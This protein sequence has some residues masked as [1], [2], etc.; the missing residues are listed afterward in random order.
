MYPLSAPRLEFHVAR[1]ETVNASWRNHGS[2]DLF[3]GLAL[4]LRAALLCNFSP[5]HLFD[6]FRNLMRSRLCE[7]DVRNALSKTYGHLVSAVEECHHQIVMRPASRPVKGRASEGSPAIWRG[8]AVMGSRESRAPA[9]KLGPAS[10]AKLL[11][12]PQQLLAAFFS[13][14]NV[15]FV[16]L[17]DRLRYLAINDALAAMNGLPAQAH[18]GKAVHEILGDVAEEVEPL[19]KHVLATGQTVSNFELTGQLPAKGEPGHWIENW[20]PIKDHQGRVKQACA[21][22]VEVTEQK[23]LEGKLRTLTGELRR[24]TE[25]LQMLLDIDTTLGSRLELQ[26]LLPAVLNCVRRAIPHD[27]VSVSLYDENLRALRLSASDS[28]FKELAVEGEVVP[29]E[30]TLSS[31]A[32]LNRETKVFR[33]ADLLASPLERVKRALELGIRSD[34][35][36]PLIT[37]KGPLGVLA[38]ASCA[39][40]GFMPADVELL[41]RVATPVA[42]ALENALIHKDLRQEKQRLQ[43]LLDVSMILGSTLNVV[44]AFPSVSAQ[45]RRVLRHEFAS[46]TLRDD[47][48]GLLRRHVWDFP[49]SKGIHS[50]APVPLPHNP[51]GKALQTRTPMIFTRDEIEGFHTEATRQLLQEGIKTLCCVPLITSQDALGTLNLGSTREKAFTP[52]DFGPLGQIASQIAAALDN[53]RAYREIEDLKDRLVEEKLYLE[54]E[55]RA[56]FNFEEIVGESAT[57][58]EALSKAQT[59]ASSDATVLILGETGTGKELIARAIHRMSRRKD[60]GF[61]KLNCAAIPT[62]LLESELIGH[63]KG[64]FTG[65]IGQKLGRMELANGGTLLLDEVGDIPLELQPKLLRVLQDHE[66]ERLGGTRTIEVDLRLIAATNRDLP[67]LIETH[68]FRSDLFYRLNV[69]PIRVPPLRERRGD[70]PML[71]RYFVRKYALRMDRNIE[72]IPSETMKALVN[73]QWPGNV[74]ELENVVERSVILTEGKTLRVPLSELVEGRQNSEPANH[75]L[76]RAEREHI[77]RVLRE[78][79]GLVSGPTGAAHRLGLKRSTLQSKML[80]LGITRDDY[81]GPTGE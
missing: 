34:V 8:G 70:I 62:G 37:G 71:V 51:Q 65:A 73:W 74:R 78:C 69:F 1:L 72:T 3:R 60:K 66:F 26:Q 6:Q 67:K 55:I 40:D 80:R 54:D 39:D 23:N 35:F 64:A 46:L 18:L 45:I 44:E 15:G 20:F 76:E 79:I 42:L 81:S 36:I 77:I 49:L 21:V 43:V 2:S 10:A 50:S 27:H 14:P 75:T 25:R 11:D 24:E 32:F 5:S 52:E 59:V 58:K 9:E 12:D 16:I 19:I 61:I 31:Q 41:K 38:V 30:E 22:I 29:L 28:L 57:L 13:A 68:Q 53:A 4:S 56:E 17:D 63:E 7:D 33:H 47:I 48:G